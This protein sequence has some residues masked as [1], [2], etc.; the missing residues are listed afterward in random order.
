MSTAK[1]NGNKWTVNEILSLQREYELLQLDIDT[2]AQRHNRTPSSIIF[3]LSSEGF[4][5][6]GELR[7][8]YNDNWLHS[9]MVEENKVP[10]SADNVIFLTTEEESDT[11]VSTRVSKLEKGLDEI[12]GMLQQVL[13]KS[14]ENKLFY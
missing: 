5:D 12:K 1:R 7:K 8:N 14:S 11:S 13:T 9:K 3:K 6:Y 4:A 10:L 2:I